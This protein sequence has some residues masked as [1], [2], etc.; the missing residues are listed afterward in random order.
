MRLKSLYLKGYANIYNAMERKELYIDFTRCKHNI[1]VIRSENGSG[2]SSIINELHPFFSSPN[3]WMDDAE[4]QKVIEFFLNDNSILT[5]SYFG[6][7][8]VNTKSKPSRCYIRRTYNDAVVELNPNGN[9]TSAKDIISD[10]LDINDDYVTLASIS[11]NSIG[12]GA[13]R[14]SERKKFISLMINSIDPYVR[15]Y[16]TLS[17]K[18]SILKSM[19]NSINAKISQIGNIEVIQ[20]NLDK[21]T[22]EL[23][24]LKNRKIELM[25]QVSAIKSKLDMLNDPMTTYN[26]LMNQK[27]ILTK[28]I[29]DIPQDVLSTS[30]IE[31]NEYK[32]EQVELNAQIDAL[33]KILNDYITQENEIRSQLEN[34]HIQLESLSNQ[35]ILDDLNAKLSK[36]K[37]DLA[38][39]VERFE[40]LG[41]KAYYDISEEE[42]TLAI[43][44]IEKFNSTIEFLSS[45]YSKDE[46]DEA[47]K[48]LSKDPQL[49]DCASLISS[50]QKDLDEVKNTI[51]Q[52][53][54]LIMKSKDYSQIPI[55]CNNLHS[56]PFIL[57]IVQAQ[58]SKISESQLELL[59]SKREEII[60]LI[61]DTKQR[62]VKQNTLLEC[63]YHIRELV[64]YTLSMSRTLLKFPNTKKVSQTKYILECISNVSYLDIDIS[65]YREY[66]NYIIL[67]S[68][69]KNDISM[70]ETRINAILNSSQESTKLKIAI[71]EK[72]A[73]LSKIYNSKVGYLAQI[74]TLKNR[75]TFVDEQVKSM[76]FKYSQKIRY[77]QDLDILNNIN[78]K[79][80]SL[81]KDIVLYKELDTKLSQYSMELDNLDLSSIPDLQNVVDQSKYQLLLYDQYKKEYAVYSDLFNK[82]ETVKKHVSINGIQA[83]IMDYTMNQILTTV[84]QL[85]SMMF[86]GRFYLHKFEITADSFNIS[87]MDRELGI[88]RPD[89][90]MMSASQLG[91]LS[92]IISFVLLHNA[93]QKYNIIRLDEIDNN[94][95][96]ENRLHF[97]GLVYNIMQSLCF[98]Q[99]VI[100]SHNTELDLTN[101]DLIITKLQNQESYK[102][103]I[104]SGA[105]I[106]ADFTI[107]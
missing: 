68:S 102:A 31:L 37:S 76:D 82:L 30:E 105:N 48:Y 13:M 67:I 51:N 52:Q 39:Y 80:D 10:L 1:I 38:L 69:I 53:T 46:V 27:S 74:K 77:E 72:T 64:N 84:N 78:A 104:N 101:C 89:I 20:S 86:G 59:Y 12:I 87:F 11:A 44:S 57:S 62:M 15:M 47:S 18:Y 63:I 98:E 61:E 14:P 22:S 23:L 41:F 6:W 24:V 60:K 91:Q 49:V 55:D 96:T 65:T 83:D 99:A 94:L 3:V 103:L 4:I 81:S 56:C 93:S 43:N 95:D 34:D 90:S 97:F 106:I 70:Y 40:I 107:N 85:S 7:K 21:A 35:D 26:E 16:K 88:I 29:S 66:T 54:D 75:K 19:I 71:E 45:Q 92:M 9:I 100:I 2:K 73:N 33:D 17:A 42:Y 58:E 25:T 36:A 32:K 79:L 28:S 5:I 50:L 8:A